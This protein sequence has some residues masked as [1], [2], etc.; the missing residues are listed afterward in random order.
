M[1]ISHSK[2]SSIVVAL[3]KWWHCD[4][5]WCGM[6]LNQVLEQSILLIK[7]SGDF[8]VA[9]FSDLSAQED[10]SE[11]RKM[12]VSEY[13]VPLS[14][15]RNSA[16][17]FCVRTSPIQLEGIKNTYLKK[18]RRTIAC[19]LSWN[20]YTNQTRKQRKRTI[21]IRPNAMLGWKGIFPFKVLTDTCFS[22]GS[23]D[24]VLT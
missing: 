17:K 4:Q 9:I 3:W 18:L 10:I 19:S 2:C 6:I 1:F 7:T 11:I 22:V 13:D 12:K 15:K 8:V 20:L 23:Y 16:A 21:M 5:N 24:R 14:L